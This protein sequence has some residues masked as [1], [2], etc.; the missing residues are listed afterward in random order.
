MFKKI[1]PLVLILG[2]LGFS[3]FA[4]VKVEWPAEAQAQATA[5]A[6]TEPTP[7]Q[8]FAKAAWNDDGMAAARILEQAGPCQWGTVIGDA[9]RIMLSSPHP[10]TL[11]LS[12]HSALVGD[13]ETIT[14]SKIGW[15]YDNQRIQPLATVTSTRCERR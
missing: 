6:Q 7:A 4:N 8:T 13:S 2:A 11:K 14:V 15:T 3:L 5:A 10:N 1:I 9:S 12:T